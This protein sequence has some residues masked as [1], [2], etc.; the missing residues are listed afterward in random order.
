VKPA[1][2]ARLGEEVFSHSMPGGLGLH[3]LPKP[4]FRASH[5]LLAVGY[6]SI[7]RCFALPGCQPLRV[8]DGVAHFLELRLFASPLGDVGDRFAALGAEVN[9]QTTFTST[10]YFFTCTEHLGECLDL[11]LE[12]VLRPTL[13]PAGVEREREIIARELQLYEDNLEW[14]S[15]T[16]ALQALYGAHPLGV[17]IAG[18][19][20]S[21]EGISAP[22]LEFCH[23]AFYRPANMSLIV[24]GDFDPEA[25]AAQVA[26]ALSGWDPGT[27][28]TLFRRPASARAGG[29]RRAVLPVALPRLYL[30]W[31]DRPP[32]AAGEA[33]LVQELCL[34]LLLDILYGSSS[35][36]YARNY[37]S[38]LID[39]ESFGCDLYVE[40]EFCF[41]LVGGDTPDPERLRVQI[42]AELERAADGRLIERDFARAARR[43]YGQ[44]V[45]RLDQVEGAVGAVFSAVGRGA[46]PLGIFAAHGQ[47]RP[48]DLQPY[49][50][51]L[52]ASERWGGSLVLPGGL[53]SRDGG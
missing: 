38:G 47:V 6:G 37:Q 22:L 9:A 5:A 35:D 45:Q 2:P 46:G 17:D 4:G 11:L 51:R 24:G 33:L 44:A 28:P 29:T 26:A 23:R 15:F 14:V 30:G 41:F 25:V 32:S 21:I 27:P 13:D 36:F 20:A 52:L 42:R 19:P 8:P 31:A 53:G 18:S 1:A 39:G 40:P 34:E 43:A 12:F 48:E 10:G 3:L 16:A 49:L 7:D 50:E